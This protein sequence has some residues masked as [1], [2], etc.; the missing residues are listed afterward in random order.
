MGFFFKKKTSKQNEENNRRK[1][2]L[3]CSKEIDYSFENKEFVKDG[4]C[5]I[6][7]AREYVEDRDKSFTYCLSCGKKIDNVLLDHRNRK[8]SLKEQCFV[9][10]HYKHSK[11]CPECDA[12]KREK[13]YKEIE[14]ERERKQ[15]KAKE[16]ENKTMTCDWCGKTY[17]WQKS[18]AEDKDV[19]C[20]KRCE[21]GSKT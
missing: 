21:S 4:F 18:T 9:D 6:K 14:E 17:L 13:I 12:L 15:K 10:Q 19:Y 20:S 11:M 1:Y 3:N 8:Y 5:S 2:C 16:M 7:C